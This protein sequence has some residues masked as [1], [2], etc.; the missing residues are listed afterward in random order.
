MIVDDKARELHLRIH[1]MWR[2]GLDTVDMSR[3]LL[4]TEAAV[5]RALHAM[6]ETK[7]AVKL[8]DTK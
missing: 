1:A 2:T 5:E 4:M 6:L 7:R 8:A 3:A